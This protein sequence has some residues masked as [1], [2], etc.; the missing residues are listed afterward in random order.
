MTFFNYNGKLY[1]EGTGVISV[2]SRGLRFGDGLF[3]TMKSRD[4]KIYQVDDHLS[5]LWKGM[6]VLDLKSGKHFT[7]QKMQQEIDALI[8]KNNHNDLARI[9]VTVFRRDGGLFDT[10]SH[11]PEYLVQTWPLPETTGSWNS[12]GLVLG[13]YPDVKKACD[14]LSNLKHNNFLPYAMAAL[15]A[16]KQHWNDALLFNAHDGI[17]DSCIA[18]V[19][20]V[21]DERLFTPALEEGCIAGITR[22]YLIDKLEAAG[23]Q[24]T[25]C[26]LSEDDL[27]LADEVF[28]TNSIYN[29]RWVQTIGEKKYRNTLTRE[30]YNTVFSTNH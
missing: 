28:L 12:N 23:M 1:P 4:G 18:N 17:C 27:M 22:K 11:A 5:R 24:V 14:K 19:F 2:N 30:I 13:I 26:R 7:A 9:R 6:D 25:A 29:L 16:K 21:K 3:E 20:L 15:H 8:K 10:I